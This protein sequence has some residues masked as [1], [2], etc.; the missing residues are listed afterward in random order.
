MKVITIGRSSENDL[1][2]ND[3]KVSRH[4]C[5]IV[6]HDDGTFTLADFGSLNGT[7]VN[8]QRVYG[9]VRLNPNDEIRIGY[10]NLPWTSCFRPVVPPRR[11]AKTLPIVLGVAGGMVATI[12]LVVSFILFSIQSKKAFEFEGNYPP[13][14]TIGLMDD[15]GNPYTV[16]AIEG[17]VCVWFEDGVSKWKAQYSIKKAGG[18]IVAQI[19]DIGYYLVQVSADEVRDFLSKINMA[20]G[21]DWASP[22]TVSY[23]CTANVYILDNY[24][25]NKGETGIYT[26]PHG[27]VV[28][29]ALE[30][31]DNGSQIEHF[32]I[33]DRDGVHPLIDGGSFCYIMN[34]DNTVVFKLDSI[35]KSDVRG[36]IIINLSYGPSLPERTQNGK[37]IKYLWDN[38][39]NTEKRTY[40][41]RYYDDIKDHIEYAKKFKKE[42]FIFV[43]SAGNEGVKE[44]DAAI[45][46]FLRK[47]LSPEERDILDKH[48]LLVTAKDTR[49][50]NYSNEMDIG[51][52]SHK[53]W[54]TKVDI[55]D[56]EYGGAPWPGTSFAAPRAAGIISSV[57]NQT[58][59]TCTEVLQLVKSVTQRDGIL[60]QEALLQA[61]AKNEDTSSSSGNQYKTIGCLK[62]RL[63]ND[64]ETD[65][66]KLELVN[67]CDEDIRV[68]GYLLNTIASHSGD[69]TLD[70]NEFVPAK[71]TKYVEGFL[72]NEC[73]IT[74]VDKLHTELSKTTQPTTTPSKSSKGIDP[75]KDTHKE[76]AKGPI[77]ASLVGTRWRGYIYNKVWDVPDTIEFIDSY[78]LTYSLWGKTTHSCHYD[79]VKNEVILWWGGG[80]YSR[81]PYKNGILYDDLSCKY[82]WRRLH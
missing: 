80:T 50:P 32:N 20:Q 31:Y 16:E 63:I 9:E 40:I 43:K 66:E 29:F 46:S 11:K 12:A 64:S 37:K 75:S 21:I 34:C 18:K 44:F 74:R 2:I 14:V 24:Y 10:T 7:Y 38:A 60:T 3:P 39:T 1:P 22:N 47:K 67:T 77:P 8:G 27:K 28:Q 25:T 69:N 57:I 54:V 45:L 42:D 19:P 78:H 33:G 36:P 56:F 52:Y 51:Y 70:F 23:P 82:A 6:Q 15:E 26:T 48:F 79:Y 49:W 17:Q 68:T 13:I 41:K 5:Q 72:E 62:Y 4:H 65:E 53:P 73:T 61:A 76:S 58:G 71:G 30:E 81:Y 55:S 35:S 59:L